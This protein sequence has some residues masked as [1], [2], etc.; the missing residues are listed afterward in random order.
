MSRERDVDALAGA[1]IITRAIPNIGRGGR[2]DGLY[3]VI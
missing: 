2:P 1:M 3:G